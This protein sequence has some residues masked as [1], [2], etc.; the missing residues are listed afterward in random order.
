MGRSITTRLVPAAVAVAMSV[1][2]AGEAFAGPMPPP[3]AR[4]GFAS[5]IDAVKYVPK[6]KPVGRAS[7]GGNPAAAAAIMGLF[8]AGIGAAIA[9]SRREERYYYPPQ[10]VYRR[11][12]A[13][14]YRE[15]EYVYQRPAPVYVAPP[16][17]QYYAPAPVYRQQAPVYRQREGIAPYGRNVVQ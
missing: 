1:S 11:P 3:P 9:N 6:K 8:A 17:R 5:Q 2:L 7:R 13:P 4:D 12:Y 16:P 10:P 14:V 15:P